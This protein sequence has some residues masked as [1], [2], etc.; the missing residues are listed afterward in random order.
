M[1]NGLRY[2][3]TKSKTVTSMR[4]NYHMKRSALCL[5]FLLRFHLYE[6]HACHYSQ[7]TEL[8]QMYSCDW[9]LEKG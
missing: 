2:Y 8:K 4:I 5:V 3:M 1:V 6:L 7:A 9:V